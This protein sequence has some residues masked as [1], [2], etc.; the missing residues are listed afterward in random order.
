MGTPGRRQRP[1]SPRSLWDCMR[2]SERAAHVGA[3]TCTF[4]RENSYGTPGKRCRCYLIHAIQS[5]RSRSGERIGY[6]QF[7]DDYRRIQLRQRSRLHRNAVGARSDAGTITNICGGGIAL[8]NSRLR[9][10]REKGAAAAAAA[11]CLA[12]GACHAVEHA[13][14]IDHLPDG[15]RANVRSRQNRRAVTLS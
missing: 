14:D 10:H 2:P 5:V 3:E 11:A 12:A 8:F 9:R 7:W 4:D 13:C 15:N 6:Q 1:P